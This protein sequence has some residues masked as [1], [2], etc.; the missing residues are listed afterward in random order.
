MRRRPDSA[1]DA[2]GHLHKVWQERINGQFEIC[3]AR[4]NDEKEMGLGSDKNP[5]YRITN[6]TTDSVS[7]RI[8]IDSS[9]GLIYVLWTEVIPPDDPGVGEGFGVPA[10]ILVYT[11][12]ERLDPSEP[13][14]STT[15]ALTDG[16]CTVKSFSVED[17]RWLLELQKGD[18]DWASSLPHLTPKP[19]SLPLL[20]PKAG[21]HTKDPCS[22]PHLKCEGILDT[23]GDGIKDS[24]EVLG[25]LG[26]FTAWWTP[27]TDEDILPD[28]WEIINKLDPMI[29]IKK[30]LPECFRGYP[31]PPKCLIIDHGFELYYSIDGD[32]I[33]TV[34]ER[35][36][37]PVTTE[38]A[39]FTHDG[40]ATYLFW[41]KVNGTY[42]LVL[43]NQHRTY[44]PGGCPN[45]NVTVEVDINGIYFANWTTT[46]SEAWPWTWSNDTIATVTLNGVDY[47]N[48]SAAMAVYLQ[49]TVL[50]DPPWC[51]SA[52]GAI[53]RAFTVDWLKL[54]LTPNRYEVN[55]KDADDFLETPPSMHVSVY[56]EEMEIW[57]DPQQR[58][59]LLELDSMVNHDFDPEV[60]NEAINVLSDLNIILNYK[61]DETGLSD[62]GDDAS[63]FV[64]WPPVSTDE[65][66]V[67]LSDHR[68]PLLGA[69]M[70]VMNVKDMPGYCGFAVQS[71]VGD[72]PEFGGVLIADQCAIDIAGGSDFLL[73]KKRLGL[74]IHEVGH[75]LG[76][77]HEVY[78]GAVNCVIDNCDVDP[79]DDLCNDYNV[80]GWGYCSDGPKATYGTG[81]FD[82]RFGSTQ[83]IGYFQFSIESFALFDFDRLLSVQ[84]GNNMDWMLFV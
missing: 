10:P 70:H 21:P 44:F 48:V 65:G 31:R 32:G 5:A 24:D 81:N 38:V 14:W 13:F 77:H 49:L 57:L 82:R 8:A 64:A 75:A 47:T 6:T 60:L 63:I 67:Y 52:Y 16:S 42:N 27:D 56:T 30:E 18:P 58:D 41:P 15:K 54:E 71:A 33:S 17:S 50:F 79:P 80:M 43:R 34:D 45:L 40:T 53:L 72:S 11:A 29:H 68:N 36:G 26:Y 66:S 9:S 73:F 25:V 7:P 39:E 2:D 51:G 69:Y 35:Q 46:W 78:N 83:P 74:L 1:K 55:Y 37:Y 4:Q 22:L 59:L 12:T 84:V 61:I 76:S 62:T 3:Y 19:C 20:K 28:R 23:D